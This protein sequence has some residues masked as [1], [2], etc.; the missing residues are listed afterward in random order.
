ML[1]V[2]ST[3]SD[4]FGRGE[5]PPGL[6]ATRA[7]PVSVSGAFTIT[8]VPDGTYVVLAAFENDL[9]V[10]DPDQLIAGTSF[11][12][13]TLPGD[14]T[15]VTLSEAFKV[16]EALAAVGPGAERPEAVTAA[17]VLEW[18]D[19]SSED[20]YEVRVFDAYGDLAWEDLGAGRRRLV[21]GE[22]VASRGHPAA[23]FGAS[24]ARLRAALALRGVELRALLSAASA[25]ALADAADRA[26]RIGAAGHDGDAAPAQVEA[27]QARAEAVAHLRF[28]QVG[29]E[30][31]VGGLD[32]AVARVDACLSALVR[33]SDPPCAASCGTETH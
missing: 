23:G 9:L 15:D 32:A 20:Y 1:V 14:S 12:T 7:G 10:R 30:A 31:G 33:H 25:D 21:T 3:L 28:A 6:R 17:P 2:E 5:V 13:V 26:R 19:D 11:V 24:L 16:T 8:G 29:G 22:V 18:A 4:T 27:V